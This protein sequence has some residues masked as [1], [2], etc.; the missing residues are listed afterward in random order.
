MQVVFVG[1]NSTSKGFGVVESLVNDIN[2][3]HLVVF[4]DLYDDATMHVSR[5]LIVMHDESQK[6]QCFIN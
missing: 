5:Y 4:F 1:E 2:V 6:F 3:Y